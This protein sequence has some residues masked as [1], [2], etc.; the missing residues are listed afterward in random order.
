MDP[1][2][3]YIEKIDEPRK[4]AYLKLL[5]ILK[6]NL[7]EG[8]KFQFGY[9]MPG[10]DVPFETYPQGY[11]TDPSHELP[12]LALGIQKGHIGLYHLGIYAD[13]KLLEWF[14]EEYKKQVPTKLNMG[15]S[16]IRFTNVKNIPYDLIAELAKKMSV[17]DYI[18]LYETNLNR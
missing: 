9:G 6:E 13:P 15:K 16:C 11:H 12:F 2:Q 14:Q 18:K 5:E 8:F 7:P 10:W 4:E 17:D 1:I 3:K